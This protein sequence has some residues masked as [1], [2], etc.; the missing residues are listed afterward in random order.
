MIPS[1]VEEQLYFSCPVVWQG[2]TSGGRPSFVKHLALGRPVDGRKPPPAPPVWFLSETPD[3]ID[4]SCLDR[5]VDRLSFLSARNF[6]I[7]DLIIGTD[8]ILP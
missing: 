1:E 8:V 4:R 7:A 5:L 6:L 2:A 3:Q